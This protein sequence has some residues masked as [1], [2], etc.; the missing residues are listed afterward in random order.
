MV[1]VFIFGWSFALWLGAAKFGLK[2]AILW[3][4]ISVGAVAL[5]AFGP[6]LV[7]K[8]KSWTRN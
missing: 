3:A 5:N 8:V 4:V 7:R 1:W 6:R 2:A